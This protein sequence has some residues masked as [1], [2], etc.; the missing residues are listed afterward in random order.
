MAEGLKAEKWQSIWN[1]DYSSKKEAE[2][3]KRFF[4]EFE[5][6]GKI[7]NL[8]LDIGSGMKP[9]SQEIR[10]NRAK[11]RAEEPDR[12]ARKPEVRIFTV[13]FAGGK[14]D[15][16]H[17]VYDIDRVGDRG[18]Y[19]TRKMLLKIARSLGIDPRTE[20]N[21][22]KVDTIIMSKI[23]Y[24]IDYKKVI[25]ELARFLKPNGRFIVIN[26]QEGGFR[27]LLS[28]NGIKKNEELP[29]FFEELGF[30]IEQEEYPYRANADNK[31]G[32]MMLVAKKPDKS[33]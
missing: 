32:V 27:R 23:L 7:G 20:E 4:G 11:S 5:E 22:E 15:P 13:D 17:L 19:S 10:T 9:V 1:F 14:D 25:V 3:L 2:F 28:E 18:R 24:Y 8:V 16:D 12:N 30:A 31:S 33:K 29:A 21:T 26:N 6:Q